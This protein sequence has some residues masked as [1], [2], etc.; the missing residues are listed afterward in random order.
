MQLLQ[1]DMIRRNKESRCRT[2]RE[3]LTL[4][5]HP[6]I[7]RCFGTFRTEKFLFFIMECATLSFNTNI[8]PLSAPCSADACLVRYCTGTELYKL[9][10]R[11]PNARFEEDEV[12]FYACQ[13]LIAL[14]HLHMMNYVY[15]DLKP[16][17]ILV[18]GNGDIK[19]ADFDLAKK[20]SLTDANGVKFVPAGPVLLRPTEVERTGFNMLL[21][22]F[23]DK[24]TSKRHDLEPT[25]VG[26]SFVGTP[27]YIAPEVISGIGD[28]TAAIDWWSYGILLFELIFGTTPFH[29][30]STDQIFS[31]IKDLEV[32]IPSDIKCS[33][34]LKDLILHLLHKDP[35]KRL[36]SRH[37]AS[38]VRK[39][40][41]FADAQLSECVVEEDGRVSCF[42]KINN[43]K[44]RAPYKFAGL[45]Y[46][47]PTKPGF[48][49][50]DR[51]IP[52]EPCPDLDAELHWCIDSPQYVP[53]PPPKASASDELGET[54]IVTR[55]VSVGGSPAGRAEGAQKTEEELLF[56]EF[57]QPVQR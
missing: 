17:N 30:H 14:E 20:G 13:I 11:V 6:N 49:I 33:P 31:N 1:E 38:E 4:M 25:L 19:L 51:W 54:Q 7:V 2:E 32:K 22:G 36:G 40:P 26:N 35:A 39:H 29:G 57:D 53:P 44:L 5:K 52:D 34:Q 46:T 15:R 37:G 21:H 23:T 12:K 48:P 28:Q 50:R 10:K 24:T 47:D 45:T 16:D 43:P 18:H 27:E 55:A 8:S 41:W 9:L 3:I 42:A 56:E